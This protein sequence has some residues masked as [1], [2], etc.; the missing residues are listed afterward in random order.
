MKFEIQDVQPTLKSN[1]ITLQINQDDENE[2]KININCE[3][4]KINVN[5]YSL[6]YICSK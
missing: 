6:D 2:A 5:N 1:D 4:N 3:I